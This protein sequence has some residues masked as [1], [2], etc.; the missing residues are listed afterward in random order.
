MCK[1]GQKSTL[2]PLCEEVKCAI[3]HRGGIIRSHFASSAFSDYDKAMDRYLELIFMD[4][5]PRRT[6]CITQI[7]L[8]FWCL[9]A[10]NRW[11]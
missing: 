4:K 10:K 1:T 8:S 5:T 6:L 2:Q 3:E 11:K 7:Q 9:I